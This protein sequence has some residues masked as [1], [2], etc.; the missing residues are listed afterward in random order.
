MSTSGLGDPPPTSKSLVKA[1]AAAVAGA[2]LLLVTIVL[3]AEYGVDPLG[4]GEV[5]G[6]TAL[7][8]STEPVAPPATE[9]LA[10]VATGPID[11]YPSEF[12]VDAREFEL[13]PYEYVE[14]K[15]HLAQGAS[16]VFS[17]AATAGVLHDFHGDRDGAPANAAESYDGEPR[18][19]ADGE[20]TAPFSGIHGWYWENPGGDTIGIRVTTAGFYT[21][22]HEF[23]FNGTRQSRPIGE[24]AAIELTPN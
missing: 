20:F 6:L 8:P 5:L 3:P 17:W 21:A 14:Y 11:L 23:R 4:T 7:R 2:A 22:A 9:I 13:G 19:R 1:V 16:M 24:L 12:H 18:A 15:Y 10:P